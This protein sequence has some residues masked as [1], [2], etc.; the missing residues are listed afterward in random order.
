M[1]NVKDLNNCNLVQWCPG[2]GDFPILLAIKQ[3]I[4]NLGLNPKDVV[5]ASGI[6]C[7][8]KLPHYIKTY[9]LES[10][11][12]RGVAAATGVQLANPNLTVIAV[13]GDGDGYGIGL[14]HFIQAVRRNVNITYIVHNNMVYGLTKGQTSPT[15]LKG[16]KS[17]STP[18]GSIEP[19]INPLALALASHGTFVARGFS[20][21]LQHLTNL[22]M[23][24][25]RHKGF[26]LVDVF[27]PCISY[28]HTQTYEFFMDNTYDLQSEGYKPDNLQEAFKKSWEWEPKV[29]IGIFYKEERPTYS[30]ELPQDKDVPVALHPIENIDIAPLL[31]K[32]Y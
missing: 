23:E 21:K 32:Y 24:G 29:P 2:C 4:A 9:G 14:N 22:I 25:I 7:S 3:A 12:G 8:G 6:G 19:P 16:T 17:P 28:N 15:A 20:G 18:H 30:D 13:G 5:V 1:T 27:Q 11:H 26:S 10:I 31:E